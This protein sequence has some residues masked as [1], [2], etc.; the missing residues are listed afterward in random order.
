LWTGP[1]YDPATGLSALNSVGGWAQLKYRATQKLQFN[2]AFGQDN[3]YA[4]DLREYGGD[5]TAHYATPL[6]RN[7]TA[8]LNF[9]YQPR[10]DIVFSME[11]RR[12]KTSAL[13]AGANTANVI[14]FSLGYIF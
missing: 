13:D 4:D 9:L 3:P 8:I 14:N 5:P 11:Y 10:S 12:L 2:A 1:L 6:S 7:Q